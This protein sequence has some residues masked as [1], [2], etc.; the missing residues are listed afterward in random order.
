MHTIMYT[1][2]IC[3][4]LYVYPLNICTLLC[5]PNTYM[6]TY[7]YTLTSQIVSI[8]ARLGRDSANY[9]YGR[10]KIIHLQISVNGRFWSKS[11]VFDF[12]VNNGPNRPTRLEVG[13]V[14]D[15]VVVNYTHKDVDQL[16]GRVRPATLEGELF[17]VRAR[18]YY[19]TPTRESNLW[20][21]PKS[22]N[23]RL[24]TKAIHVLDLCAY[25]HIAPERSGR[26]DFVNL[27]TVAVAF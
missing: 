21:A 10:A 17:F 12:V 19:P 20:V 15:F 11:T 24:R 18:Q 22:P 7:M 3:V 23:Y 5:I 6:Y 27:V 1:R 14:K 9:S 4:H 25:L 2:Y 16:R 26:R 13:L 8:Q